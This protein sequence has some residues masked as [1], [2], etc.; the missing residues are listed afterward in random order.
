MS[1]ID[2]YIGYLKLMGY[3]G[4]KNMDDLKAGYSIL[5]KKSQ[6]SIDY[7]KFQMVKF[8]YRDDPDCYVNFGVTMI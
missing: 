5:Y 6:I 1:K 8:G 7:Q 3:G 4:L 2:T